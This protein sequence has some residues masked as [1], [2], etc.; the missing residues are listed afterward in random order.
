MPKRVDLTG[1]QFGR[2]TVLEEAGQLPIGKDQKLR[3]FWYC[4]CSCGG[5]ALATSGDLK[6][7]R[8]ATCQACA[9][10]RRVAHG[11]ELAESNIRHGGRR[12]DK[13]S[14]E[15]SA[16]H[17]VRQ[18]DQVMPP[19][20][21]DFQQFFKDVGWKPSPEHQLAR[22]DNRRPHSKENTY[23]RD[24]NAEDLRSYEPNPSLGLRGVRAS[25]ATTR[26]REA[27]AAAVHQ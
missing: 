1:Q 10:E 8:V 15:Y 6:S 26:S 14:P 17:N 9:K 5:M 12:R 22:H 2:L 25:A 19:E 18:S 21:D 20:W 4:D 7:G 27:T 3:W 23:W 24:P 16:W 11:K 13:T